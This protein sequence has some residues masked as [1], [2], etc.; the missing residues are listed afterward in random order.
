[1]GDKDINKQ[2][3]KNLRTKSCFIQAAKEIVL[4]EGVENVSVRKVA[5]QAGYTFATIYNYFKDLNE[6]LQ[7]VKNEM[8]LDVMTYMQKSVPE[9][10]YDLDDVKKL[11]HHYI[12]YYIERPNV[13]RF[14]YS[15]RLHSVIEP[16][17]EVLDYSKLYFDTYRGFVIGGVIKEKEIPVIAKTIIYTLH[18]LLALYFSDNGMTREMLYDE[19]NKTIEYLLERRY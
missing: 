14:F 9:K 15:Y 16:Q 18:G 3:I 17:E 12:D 19:M 4:R 13:F 2:S 7:E 11:N 1:M 5:D 8:I 6:L 10:I